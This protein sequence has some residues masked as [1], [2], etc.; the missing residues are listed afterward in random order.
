MKLSFGQ[1]VMAGLFGIQFANGFAQEHARQVGS[2]L[3]PEQL[4]F[5]T[6]KIVECPQYQE[7]ISEGRSPAEIS[8]ILNVKS[9]NKTNFENLTGYQWPR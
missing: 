9:I 2:G 6:R 4:D 8:K 7:L 5:V 3:T 1:K